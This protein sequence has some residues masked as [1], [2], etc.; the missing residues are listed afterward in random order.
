MQIW[1]LPDLVSFVIIME[2]ENQW[3]DGSMAKADWDLCDDKTYRTSS[4]SDDWD[5]LP[6]FPNTKSGRWTV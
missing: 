3:I 5:T 1:L 2:H 4:S 6:W